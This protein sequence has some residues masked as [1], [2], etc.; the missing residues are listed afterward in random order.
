MLHLTFFYQ[1]QKMTLYYIECEY[2]LQILIVK[3]ESL[4][5]E[6]VLFYQRVTNYITIVFFN[7][8]F[9]A[10]GQK[11]KNLFQRI[12]IFLKIGQDSQ[13]IILQNPSKYFQNQFVYQL[14]NKK[15]KKKKKQI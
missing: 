2:K 10:L 9:L 7:E 15:K 8:N 14:Q 12:L 5:N 13:Q 3:V 6:L 11:Q 4:F 1:Y